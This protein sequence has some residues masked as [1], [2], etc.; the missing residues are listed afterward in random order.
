[1][2]TR[3]YKTIHDKINVGEGLC[4][5]P[6]PNKKQPHRDCFRLTKKIKLNIEV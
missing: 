5:L 1:M 3:P 4:A 6:K 2:E